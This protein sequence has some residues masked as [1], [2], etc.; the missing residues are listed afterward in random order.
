MLSAFTVQR[1]T[2]ISLAVGMFIPLDE[3]FLGFA[4]VLEKSLSD[5]AVELRVQCESRNRLLWSARNAAIATIGSILSRE[6]REFSEEHAREKVWRFSV[7]TAV[8]QGV[9]LTE[10]AISTARYAQA[11]ALVRQEVESVEVISGIRQGKQKPRK[12]PQLKVLKHLKAARAQL[13]GMTHLTDPDL[14]VLLTDCVA[15]GIDLKVNEKFERFLLG[16]HVTALVG[17]ALDMSDLRPF[18]ERES[19]DP[20]ENAWLA[21]VC[22]VLDSEGFLTVKSER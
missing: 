11:S 14:T 19:L 21:A 1:R 10:T 9:N 12:T 22:G 6:D 5:Q 13:S 16:L 18:S 3:A 4:S 8:V 15:S 2:Q 20:Q 17:L 7:H